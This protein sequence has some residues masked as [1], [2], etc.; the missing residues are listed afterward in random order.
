MTARLDDAGLEAR[1]A[2]WP[3][4]LVEDNDGDADLIADLI[5]EG[6]SSPTRAVLR[7]S[8]LAEAVD[9]LR[10]QRVAAVLLDLRLPD[11]EGLECVSAV[12][13]QAGDAPIVVLTG[14]EDDQL[15]LSCMTAGA[16]DYLSKQDIRPRV[17]ARAIDYAI[18]RAGEARERLRA[19]ALRLRSAELEL[20][21]KRILEDSRRKGL[22]LANMSHELRTPLNAIIG[23]SQLMVDGAPSLE[24][25]VVQRYAG[26]ILTSGRHLLALINDVLDLARIEAAGLEL[27]PCATAVAEVAR[28]VIDVVTGSFTDKP[29]QVELAVDPALGPVWTDPLRLR[30]V[31]YNYLSNAWKFTPAN[32]R[33][34]VRVGSAGAGRFRIEVQDTGPGIGP[35][36]LRRLFTEFT[37]L[38]CEERSRYRGTG[39]GLALTKR[40]VEAQGG[41]VGAHSVPGQGATFFAELPDPPPPVEAAAAPITC[42]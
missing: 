5:A 36:D 32:G 8:R 10:R 24:G 39:L 33:L 28:E 12:R 31:L 27:H 19:Q 26:H 34:V 9:T 7:A 40:I 13:S 16:Q 14:M 42:P 1:R 30:Q 20:E 37:Q 38:P 3:I 22:N 35:A 4:L 15:A 6:G 21:N 17:L 18:V 41:H 29:M 25:A 23:F 2:R 11:A